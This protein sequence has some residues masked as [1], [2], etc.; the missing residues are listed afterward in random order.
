MFF[1]LSEGDKT[2]FVS[3]ERI[4]P[5]EDVGSGEYL[6]TFRPEPPGCRV[7][8]LA[9]DE[10]KALLAYVNRAGRVSA[11]GGCPLS[12]FNPLPHGRRLGGDSQYLVPD[13]LPSSDPREL[14]VEATRDALLRWQEARRRVAE[15]EASDPEKSDPTNKWGALA[16][17]RVL[18]AE[19]ALVLAILACDEGFR[20]WDRHRA[21]KEH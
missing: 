7:V 9:G 15:Y 19:H 18:G 13:D 17:D 20:D 11:E 5:I 14:A 2:W 3:I 6:V 12:R 1:K 21:V 4:H 10:A 16:Y 8:R